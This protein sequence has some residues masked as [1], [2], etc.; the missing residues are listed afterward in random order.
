M[1]GL[2]FSPDGRLLVAGSSFSVATGGIRLYRAPLFSETG[3]AKAEPDRKT[4]RP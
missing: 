2:L 1:R 3:A 4:E